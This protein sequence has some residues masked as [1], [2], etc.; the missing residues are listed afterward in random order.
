VPLERP[1]PSICKDVKYYEEYRE[2]LE[3]VLFK[4]S[5]YKS[6]K[7]IFEATD[8]IDDTIEDLIKND[9]ELTE[10]TIKGLGL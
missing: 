10:T 4:C 9:L 2:A 3:R 7:L 6:M 1:D 8:M 5:D